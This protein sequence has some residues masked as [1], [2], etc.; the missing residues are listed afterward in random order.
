MLITAPKT[1]LNNKTGA[2]GRL[3]NLSFIP[4]NSKTEGQRTQGFAFAYQNTLQHNSSAD[5]NKTNQ[6]SNAFRENEKMIP[7][8]FHSEKGRNETTKITV[9]NSQLLENCSHITVQFDNNQ[10]SII[11]KFQTAL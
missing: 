2:A 9:S 7:T 11:Q 6:T 10:F 1:Q 5:K 3:K 4:L 8:Q